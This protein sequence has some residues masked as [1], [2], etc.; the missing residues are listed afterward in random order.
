MNVEA[1]DR[2]RR[3]WWPRTWRGRTVLVGTMTVAVLVSLAVIAFRHGP[4]PAASPGSR[5]VAAGTPV[6]VD[7]PAPAFARPLLA[8]TG[9]L[10]LSAYDHRIVV[11]NFWA[12]DCDACRTEGPALGRLARSF[13]GQGVR[14]IGVDYEDSPR[15][16]VRF[17][18]AH[19]MR[20]PSV[21]D[22]HGTLGDAYRIFG[23]PTTFIIGP[24]AR[25]RYVV[26]GKIDVSSFRATLRSMLARAVR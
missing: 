3:G 1:G 25:I 21:I 18:R 26:I 11:L 22:P 19:G 14:F 13:A 4:R 23:L 10:K 5:G 9:S 2:G 8:R 20:Y 12:S 7:R 24:G 6:R 16:A 17:A 15:A